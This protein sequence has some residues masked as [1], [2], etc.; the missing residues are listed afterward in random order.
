MRQRAQTVDW[1]IFSVRIICE[2]ALFGWPSSAFGAA[3]PGWLQLK[4]IKT[5]NVAKVRNDAVDIV[6]FLP[7][8]GDQVINLPVYPSSIA[9]GISRMGVSRIKTQIPKILEN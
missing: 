2:A 1:N 8:C 9:G 4:V 3:F 5:N 7:E 6:D